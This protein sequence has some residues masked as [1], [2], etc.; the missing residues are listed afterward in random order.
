MAPNNKTGLPEVDGTGIPERNGKRAA[1]T[2]A[3]KASKVK[4]M[5]S[6]DKSSAKPERVVS[7]NWC[8]DCKKPCSREPCENP[9]MNTGALCGAVV[10]DA[11]DEAGHPGGG[12]CKD[13]QRWAC[14]GCFGVREFDAGTFDKYC[15]TCLIPWFIQVA[16]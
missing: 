6:S 4:K 8:E 5:A 16:P 9:H 1:T 11:C 10:C 15:P 3:K 2:P 7:K 13:C 12:F 14:G